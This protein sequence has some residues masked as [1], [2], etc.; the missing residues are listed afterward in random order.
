MKNLLYIGNNLNHRKSNPSSIR[1]LGPLLEQEGYRVFY[2][3]SKVSK[4]RR[5]LD[6]LW[7]CLRL[8]K[9]VEVV[10]IDTYST[11]NFYYALAVS[12][13]CRLLRLP[14]I[15]ILHGGNLPSR[16]ESSPKLCGLIFRHAKCC[17]SPSPYLQEVFRQAGYSQ[18]QYIPNALVLENYPYHFKAVTD[19]KLLWVRSF[20]RLYNPDLAVE[21]L[22]VLRQEGLPASLCMVGPDSDG[23][24][25]RVKALADGLGVEVTFTGKL[26]KNEWTALAKDCTVFINTTNFDNMPVSVIEAMA[27]G[28]PVVSTNVG[29]LPYLIAHERDGLLVPPNKAEAFVHAIKRLA[30]Q[31]V[32]AE[33][34][35]FNARKQV[36][37]FDW[38]SVRLQWHEVLDA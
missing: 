9:Q 8:R 10:V 28:L 12:Q 17:V 36:E 24:M 15:P 23:S 1:V 3:S 21:V 2:A 16:L 34:L 14:Y 6:M 19:L 22:S 11:Q 29:G 26:T 31:P 4:V 20:A 33:S 13:L 30:R 18:V 27:L 32:F 7:T 38:E 5:L 25:G 37:R 35:A